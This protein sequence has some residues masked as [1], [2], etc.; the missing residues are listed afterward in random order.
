MTT[1][2]ESDPALINLLA[3]H[4]APCPRCAYNLRGCQ[5][6]TCPEC[7]KPFTFTQLTTPSARASLPWAITL[8]AW[9]AALPWSLFDAWQRLVF[10]RKLFYGVYSYIESRYDYVAVDATWTNPRFLLSAAFWLGVP[11]VVIVIVTL[12]RRIERLP[13]WLRWFIALASALLFLLAFRRW[14]WWYYDM[15]FADSPV[16]GFWFLSRYNRNL[17]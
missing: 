15:G 1:Q 2:T 3:R 16:G 5:S 14:Q 11:F 12:R 13:L 10:R 8:I 4:D 17:P 9:A 7:G 6:N